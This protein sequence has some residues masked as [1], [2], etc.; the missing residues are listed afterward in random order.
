MCFLTCSTSCSYLIISSF[1]H[2]L[3][4]V[5]FFPLKVFLPT[6]QGCIPLANSSGLLNPLSVQYHP[7]CV[8]SRPLLSSQLCALCCVFILR[9]GTVYFAQD[10][11]S[12]LLSV[13]YKKIQSY[14]AQLTKIHCTIDQNL[15]QSR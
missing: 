1:L 7:V 6:F 4:F 9:P 5:L 13:S 14:I 8:L 3:I 2:T 11:Y 15:N 10:I 12:L